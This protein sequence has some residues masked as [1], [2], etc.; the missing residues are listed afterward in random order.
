MEDIGVMT[1]GFYRECTDSYMTVGV[2]AMVSKMMDLRSH[3]YYGLRLCFLSGKWVWTQRNLS[4]WKTGWKV[5]PT[6]VVLKTNPL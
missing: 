4:R 6:W 5:C 3:Y 1:M 2:P